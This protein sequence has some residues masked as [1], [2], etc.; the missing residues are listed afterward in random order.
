MLC[1]QNKA[2]VKALTSTL[3]IS[4]QGMCDK[5]AVKVLESRGHRFCRYADDCLGLI[6]TVG[7]FKK[8]ELSFRASAKNPYPIEFSKARETRD[9]SL[10][11][12]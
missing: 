4:V 9:P 2:E 8:T 5:L 7:L 1:T 10:R 6:G 12:G 3:F 11:S